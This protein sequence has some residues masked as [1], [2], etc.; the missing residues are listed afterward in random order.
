MFVHRLLSQ[1]IVFVADGPTFIGWTRQQ[2]L[3]PCMMKILD[4]AFRDLSLQRLEGNMK[5]NL[6][7]EN[8]HQ[9]TSIILL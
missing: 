1:G 5:K 2:G 9:V 3:I 4:L 8:T 7:I 6:F